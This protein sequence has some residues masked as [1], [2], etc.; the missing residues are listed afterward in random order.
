MGKGGAR[1]GAGRPASRQ[2]AEDSY[3]IDLR[4]LKR[5]GFVRNGFTG[6]WNWSCGGEPTGSVGIEWRESAMYLRYTI[7][8]GSGGRRDG[9]Q[10]VATERTPCPFGGERHWFLCPACNTRRLMLVMRW[11][12]FA[13]T[14]CQKI[15]YRSQSGDALDRACNRYHRLAALVEAPRPARQ[16]RATREKLINRY[17]EASEAFDDLMAPRLAAIGWPL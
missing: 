15:S 17:I 9:S 11:G 7:G 6:S 5:C 8:D 4:H 3:R 10:S 14:Q 13:C 1:Y 16:R 2:Q 12:R